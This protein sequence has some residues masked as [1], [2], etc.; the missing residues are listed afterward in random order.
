MPPPQT[1]WS[2]SEREYLIQT[3]PT[4][5]AQEQANALGRSLA[6][7][8][9][10][11]SLLLQS[12]LVQPTQRRYNPAWT[13]DEQYSV[14]E[15]LDRGWSVRK[16]AANMPGRSAEAICSWVERRGYQLKSL[17]RK[18]SLA[19]LGRLF[20]VSDDK[21]SKVWIKRGWLAASYDKIPRRQRRGK[22]YRRHI[23]VEYDALMDFLDYRPAWPYW[24]PAW[25]TDP[26][27]REAAEDC[28]AA[29]GGHWL[30][31]ADV[32]QRY[33]YCTTPVQSWIRAGLLK[34]T[35]SAYAYYIW[36]TDLDG[37]VPPQAAQT[38]ASRSDAARRS[39]ITR[40]ANQARQEAAP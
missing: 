18:Y 5:T 34:A 22:Q 36:S 9:H 30:S 38:S 21:I 20:G 14:L 17:R 12:G 8:N 7:V 39:H 32:A 3:Y 28:R 4:H 31:V 23:Y 27:W 6:S 24:Q 2:G 33:H 16:I 1:P 11:R 29:A 26:D 40:R 13:A 35:K 19:E 15:Y 25:I 10:V 37:F